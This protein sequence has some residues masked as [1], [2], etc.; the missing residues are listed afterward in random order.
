MWFCVAENV[1]WS[2][3]MMFK[4]HFFGGCFLWLCEMLWGV[5]DQHSG[6]NPGVGSLIPTA[7]SSEVKEETNPDKEF[8][9]CSELHQVPPLHPCPWEWL[10]RVW[11]LWGCGIFWKSA[12]ML[13]KSSLTGVRNW[14]FHRHSGDAHGN[15]TPLLFHSVRY[16]PQGM[17]A[18]GKKQGKKKPRG[19]KPR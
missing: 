19:K 5:W 16:I 10:L 17:T 11:Q 18:E 9:E 13:L 14:E 4:I 2:W 1:G 7:G 12:I 3:Q 6:I 15:L 8:S